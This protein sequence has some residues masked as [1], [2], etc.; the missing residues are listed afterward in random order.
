MAAITF[1][2]VGIG[3]LKIT[4][5]LC[6]SA[7]LLWLRY[8]FPVMAIYAS[9]VYGSLCLLCIWLSMPPLYIT[10][11]S[12]LLRARDAPTKGITAAICSIGEYPFFFQTFLF[13]LK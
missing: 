8:F 7:A 11:S 5:F 10:S 3:A 4:V 9:F 6:V 1:D 2:L 12:S 13:S